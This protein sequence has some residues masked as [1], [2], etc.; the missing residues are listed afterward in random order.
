MLRSRLWA[1]AHAGSR[2][3]WPRLQRV[4]CAFT[5]GAAATKIVRQPNL[6]TRSISRTASP[7]SRSE[8]CA[9]GMSRSSRPTHVSNAQVL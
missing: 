5:T 4:P 3:G 2:S 8:M 1:A 9:A 7:G 6:A